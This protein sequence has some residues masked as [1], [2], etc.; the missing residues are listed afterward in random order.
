[1]GF[2][3][4]TESIVLVLGGGA[5]A[6][7]VTAFISRKKVNAEAES[8]LSGATMEFVKLLQQDIQ[9]LRQRVTE[10]D[11]RIEQEQRE[12]NETR[13]KL[14]A[15]ENRVAQ[16]EEIVKIANERDAKNMMLMQK[17]AEAL[18]EYNPTHPLITAA[19]GVK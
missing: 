9:T 19:G 5:V 12:N 15:A 13:T 17:L 11:I 2:D 8:T 4:I 10:S 18:K 14:Q 3:K 1:M 7:L 6:S 16:L